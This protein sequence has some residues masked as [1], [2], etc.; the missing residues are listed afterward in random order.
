MHQAVM[1]AQAVDGLDVRAGRDNGIYVDGTFG[2]GG[3]SRR[4]LQ[5]LGGSGK[6]IAVD[7]DPD[8][9]KAG[10]ALH[11]KRLTLLHGRFGELQVL[12]E[13]VGVKK[14]DGILLDL[15]VSSPQLDDAVRGFS[16][17]FDAPLDMRMDTSQ[18]F[19][20]AQWLATADEAEIREVI[21]RLQ[22]RLLRLERGELWAPH[23]NLPRSWRTPSRRGSHARTLRRARF[24]LSAFT[25][26]RNSRSS[27]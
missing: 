19:T 10:A 24:R 15:G 8:A 20:A 18:G 1:L 17:R 12:L 4:I 9:I 16:F 21:N 3:H 13:S 7:R 14:V 25:S 6:L 5:V 22:Q 23:D 26:I 11:D 27:R 2:R